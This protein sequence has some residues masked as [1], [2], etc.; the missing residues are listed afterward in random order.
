MMATG[1]L[2]GVIKC[3]QIDYRDDCLTKYIKNLWMAY[4]KLV[5]CMVCEFYLIK[6]VIKIDTCAHNTLI[7]VIKFHLSVLFYVCHNNPCIHLDDPHMYFHDNCL[8]FI[9]CNRLHI[10]VKNR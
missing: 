2:H 1:F 3:S 7:L 8:S 6:A 4:F 9:I 5:T 10:F